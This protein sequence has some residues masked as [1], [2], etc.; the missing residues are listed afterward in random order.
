MVSLSGK[1]WNENVRDEGSLDM[2][3]MKRYFFIRCSYIFQYV[4]GTLS[5]S[6]L[7]LFCRILF[8]FDCVTTVR[9]DKYAISAK[10]QGVC[11]SW[12]YRVCRSA[13]CTY[14][15][16][17]LCWW[18]NLHCTLHAS[19][20]ILITTEVYFGL[21]VFPLALQILIM[22]RF[23]HMKRWHYTISQPIANGP[24]L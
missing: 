6:L 20:S 24:S 1:Y 7:L 23:S 2:K 22:R 9:V 12:V 18:W 8:F 14:S 13:M 5:S 11:A 17:L 4:D 16:R 15:M 10:N 19:P 21:N 3:R